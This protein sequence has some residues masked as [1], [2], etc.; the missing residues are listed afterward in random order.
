MHVYNQQLSSTINTYIKHIIYK[1]YLA[2]SSK[3]ENDHLSLV[4]E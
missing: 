2:F 3:K 4:I 1:D